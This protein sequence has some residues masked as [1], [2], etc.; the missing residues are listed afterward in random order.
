MNDR[1]ARPSRILFAAVQWPAGL[2]LVLALAPAPA[3]A[4]ES[5]TFDPLEMRAQLAPHRYTTLSAEMAA[6]I[7]RIAYQDGAAFKQGEV[8]MEFDCAL[9]AAQLDKARAHQMATEATL[10]GQRSLAKLNAVGMVE[11]KTSEAEVQK[12]KAD[13]AYLR[14][15]IDRCRIRGPFDGRI[16][17][18]EAREQQFVQAGQPLIEV[19]DDSVLELEFIVPSRWLSW[20]KPGHAFDVRIEDTGNEYPVRLLRTAARVDPVSQSVKAVAVIDGAFPE[21]I[22]G[23]SGRILLSP[24]AK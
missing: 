12:A 10:E 15:M 5:G 20:F 24:P 1:H 23:M 6:R 22:P 3:Q 11:V 7:N 17:E 16:V 8:L 9:Q 19:I 21:L 4:Q 13:V 18:H 2:C 14:A